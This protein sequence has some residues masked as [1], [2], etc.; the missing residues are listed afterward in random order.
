MAFRQI[1]EGLRNYLYGPLKP[2]NVG[3][4]TTPSPR[5]PVGPDGAIPEG[6]RPIPNSSQQT[7]KTNVQIPY[8]RM[9]LAPIPEGEIV[10]V[11]HAPYYTD[12][13]ASTAHHEA[14]P[15]VQVLTL[16]QANADLEASAVRGAAGAPLPMERR[17]WLDGDGR[18]PGEAGLGR[19]RLDGVVNNSEHEEMLAPPYTGDYGSS[20][21]QVNVAVQ[22]HVRL[23]NDD[24]RRCDMAKAHCGSIVYV[25][26]WQKFTFRPL[27]A[28]EETDYTGANNDDRRAVRKAV[29]EDRGSTMH[30]RF[31]RFSSTMLTAGKYGV[32]TKAT[33]NEHSHING[34]DIGLYCCSAK[35]VNGKGLFAPQDWASTH[36]FREAQSDTPDKY[37][38]DLIRSFGNQSRTEEPFG[39][40][41]LIGAYVLGMTADSN[42]SPNMLTVVVNLG[43][44]DWTG[45]RNE[46]EL[47]RA[48]AAQPDEIVRVEKAAGTNGPTHFALR[49][50][51]EWRGW[52][53]ELLTGAAFDARKNAVV[54]SVDITPWITKLYD[55]I[56]AQWGVFVVT[57]AYTGT[58]MLVSQLTDLLRPGALVF[59][60]RGPVARLLHAQW[61]AP[62]DPN[63]WYRDKK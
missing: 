24:A 11:E 21:C 15:T 5:L 16:E 58:R 28:V 63:E 9:A 4:N 36:G 44:V 13:K 51:P 3:P 60:G 42:Q 12:R 62:G 19:Y 40:E 54:R 1:N 30:Y 59:N 57:N 52:R 25:G 20:L 56:R 23:L 8:V 33:A 37:K 6:T 27:T 18:T 26:V 47:K 39:F 48:V 31:E 10:V 17:H 45:A 50:L 55:Q 41:R 32:G 29:L 14:Q 46:V 49:M 61:V 38:A 2:T 43:F 34:K 35:D 7:K 53:P 22:G